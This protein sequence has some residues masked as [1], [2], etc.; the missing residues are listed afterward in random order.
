MPTVL[1]HRPGCL[2]S[3]IP[4]WVFKWHPPLSPIWV[5]QNSS[6]R[7]RLPTCCS[8]TFC[9]CI[10]QGVVLRAL[11]HTIRTWRSAATTGNEVDHLGS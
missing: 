4:K 5:E 11:L 1:R 2:A 9:S 3:K 7:A 6:L 10:A 8:P